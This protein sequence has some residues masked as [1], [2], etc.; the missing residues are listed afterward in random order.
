MKSIDTEL[1]SEKTKSE[2][3]KQGF[4]NFVRDGYDMMIGTI[5]HK[6]GFLGINKREEVVVYEFNS[7]TG[8]YQLN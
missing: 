1:T 6:S 7:K 2:L 4:R 5:V 8:N 3:L